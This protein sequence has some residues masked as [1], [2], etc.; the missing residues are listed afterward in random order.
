VLV[1]QTANGIGTARTDNNVRRAVP[2][3]IVSRRQ[4]EIA[5]LC[6]GV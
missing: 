3:M 1:E 5:Q 6:L 2:K 4:I